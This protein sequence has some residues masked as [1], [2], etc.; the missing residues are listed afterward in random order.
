MTEIQLTQCDEDKSSQSGKLSDRS[1]E[2]T[3]EDLKS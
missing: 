1:L 2:L 3:K